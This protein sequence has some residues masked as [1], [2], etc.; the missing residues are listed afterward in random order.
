MQFAKIKIEI[1]LPMSSILTI[2]LNP[3]IDKST[4]VASMQPEKK[5]RCTA[6]VFE[7]GGGG[8]NVARAIKKL[9][10]EATAWYLAGG[11]SGQFFTQLLQKENIPVEVIHISSH[12]RENLVVL[13]ESNNHQYRFG[14]P[15]PVVKEEE[16]TALLHKLENAA[17]YDYIV[18]SG[19]VPAG[20]PV[21]IFGRIGAIARKKGAKFILDTSGEPLREGVQQGAYL[22][23]PNKGEL[24]SLLGK[25]WL[26]DGEIESAAKE[27]IKRGGAEIL[28][29]SLGGE[30]ALLVIKDL[31]KRI[32][33]PPVEKKS[34]VG[35]GDS[36]VAGIIW[37]LS[38]GDDILTAAKYGV[39]CGTAATINP[40][41]Q[42]CRR[43]DADRLFAALKA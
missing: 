35:A 43:E 42:L 2:T 10:G 31:V 16:W 33:P 11:Y 30:G 29:V 7:P 4:T 22:L 40:G 24:C 38:I 36:M 3:A 37:R 23:K 19:S 17:G 21:N 6:P 32:V 41:T 15:G 25:E 26:A 27:I 14:M 39:A 28:V 12:T 20:V 9:E 34:T 8:I 1:I 5:L 18:C 13:D